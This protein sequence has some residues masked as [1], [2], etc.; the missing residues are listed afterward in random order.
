AAFERHGRLY[1]D[2]RVRA[3]ASALL[4]GAREQLPPLVRRDF[5]DSGTMHVLVVSGLHVGFVA[6]ALYLALSLVLGRGWACS[7]A[8]S[9]AVLFFALVCGARP[10]VLRASLMCAFVLMALPLQRRKF[11]LNIL[12]AAFALILLARPGWIADVGFQLSFAAVAGIG[13]LVPRLEKVFQ[14]LTW[15]GLRPA[16]RLVQLALASLAAQAAVT[17]L[18]A[19]YF[20][21]VSPAALV[22]NLLIVPLA[23]CAVVTG[24]VADLLAFIWLPVARAAALFFDISVKLLLWLARWFAGLPGACLEVN[25]PALH[26]IFLWWLFVFFAAAALTAKKHRFR[27]AVVC[28]IWLNLHLWAPAAA[29]LRGGLTMRFLDLGGRGHAA[30][31]HLPGRRVLFL[32]ARGGRG[33]VP[34]R[35]VVIPYLSRYCGSGIDLLVLQ[36]CDRAGISACREIL[37]RFEVGSLVV[38]PV[39]SRAPVYREFLEA[40]LARGVALAAPTAA[41]TLDLGRARLVVLGPGRYW[42]DLTARLGDTS[43]AGLLSVVEYAGRRV[44]LAGAV[45]PGRLEQA[46]AGRGLLAGCDLAELPS[47]FNTDR[48]CSLP[49]RLDRTGAAL[50]VPHEVYEEALLWEAAGHGRLT[51]LSTP[52]AGAVGLR[53]ERSGKVKLSTE[54]ERSGRLPGW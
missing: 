4:L 33:D 39:V 12:A 35:E 37:E 47:G 6:G 18:L 24:L 20:L 41:D 5:T 9:L 44:L 42:P 1:K 31:L 26:D 11:L 50:I 43:G 49:V 52:V 15:W 34:V 10:S 22:A 53:I 16:R 3:V 28:L 8:V 13:L 25:P 19:Y 27:L 48:A 30:A 46:Q 38:P 14:G 2:N 51:V 45:Q 36:G 40:C 23:G 17:P 29:E 21:R 54:L 32:D 7:S